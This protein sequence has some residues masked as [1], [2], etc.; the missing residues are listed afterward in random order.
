MSGILTYIAL[1]GNADHLPTGPDVI[2]TALVT[3]WLSFL[4]REVYSEAFKMILVPE[5][6]IGAGSG[7]DRIKDR[8]SFLVYQHFTKTEG[9]LAGKAF[10][11]AGR[12]TMVDFNL[13]L[14]ARWYKEL[15]PT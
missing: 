6:F 7:H 14:F 15:W 1:Q 12:I 4:D 2:E 11:I 10:A 13:Y 8:G 9:L 3:D 5:V